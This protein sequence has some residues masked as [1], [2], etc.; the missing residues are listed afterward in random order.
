MKVNPTPLPTVTLPSSP[1]AA[2]AHA[3]D[4]TVRRRDRR[5][6]R[7]RQIK[8][9]MHVPTLLVRADGSAVR[10]GGPHCARECAATGELWVALKGSVA[11]HPAEVPHLAAATGKKGLQLAKAN[12]AH[13][14][15]PSRARPTFRHL[16]CPSPPSPSLAQE[17]VCCNA[18]ALRERMALLESLGYDTPPPEGF[19]VWRIDPAR[20]DPQAAR[21]GGALYEAA[22][23]PPMVAVDQ[24]GNCWVAQAR[25]RAISPRLSPAAHRPAP[26][27]TCPHI[28]LGAPRLPG[29]EP[30]AAGHR[31][32]RD[33]PGASSDAAGDP[34][35][36]QAA[37]AADAYHRASDRGRAR[38]RRVGLAARRAGRGRARRR[39]NCTGSNPRLADQR[40]ASVHALGTGPGDAGACAVRPARAAVD[41]FVPLHPHGLRHG[42]APRVDLR[43]QDRRPRGPAVH[44]RHLVQPRRG[45]RDQ[46]APRRASV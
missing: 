9:I 14:P 36:C 4:V 8:R 24:S 30:H 15:L 44:V 2:A 26:S 11:C 1:L 12:S 33:R 41:D 17:R 27:H 23:S 18:A 21:H 32:C 29:P 25:S 40:P 13:L 19:A 46:R 31:P 42:G 34:A 28:G 20:Y 7:R 45:R 5:R 10:V 35:P 3:L 39:P 22:P 38:R 43:R 16:P 6:P 37:A